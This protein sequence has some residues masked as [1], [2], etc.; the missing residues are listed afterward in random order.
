MKQK[1]KLFILMLAAAMV[2]AMCCLAGCGQKKDVPASKKTS[3]NKTQTADTKDTDK[4]AQTDTGSGDSSSDS[5]GNAYAKYD[6]YA[7]CL[8]NGD[9]KYRLATKDGFSMHCFFQSDSPE[10]TE[11]VYKMDLDSAVRTGDTLTIKKIRDENGNDISD[12]YKK[13]TYT[14]GDGKVIMKVECDESKLAGGGGDNILSG[15]Y[16]FTAPAEKSPKKKASDAGAD[17]SDARTKYTAAELGKLAQKYYKKKNDFYPPQADVTKN[18]DGTFTIH[19]YE[20]VDNGDGTY[21]TATSAWYRVNEYGAGK[22]EI[23]N[24]KVDITE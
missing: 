18:S 22:N 8:D 5:K 17:S 7:Y 16:V 15:K 1:R 11:V 9:V 3:G 12:K 6:G 19:L 13:L 4:K 21:H 24:E 23:T 20:K 14:F 10:Y 2:M